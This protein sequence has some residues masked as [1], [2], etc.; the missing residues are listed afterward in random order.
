MELA[1]FRE[2]RVFCHDLD[3][4]RKELVSS[5]NAPALSSDEGNFV[6]ALIQNMEEQAD[7]LK[8]DVTEAETNLRPHVTLAD[9]IAKCSALYEENEAR[10][11]AMRSTLDR[12]Q[13]D[14]LNASSS[15]IQQTKK[16]AH[17]KQPSNESFIGHRLSGV[18]MTNK[19]NNE[20]V[21]ENISPIVLGNSRKGEPKTPSLEDFGISASTMSYLGA[22]EVQP[23]MQQQMAATYIAA[24]PYSSSAAFVRPVAAPVAHDVESITPV[25]KLS[26]DYDPKS[27]ECDRSI[28]VKFASETPASSNCASPVPSDVSSYHGIASASNMYK[29]TTS[30]V[31]ISQQQPYATPQ[32]LRNPLSVRS[33]GGSNLLPS[34]SKRSTPPKYRKTPMKSYLSSQIVDEEEEEPQQTYTASIGSLSSAG[35]SQPAQE[36]MSFRPV[37]EQ[38]LDTMPDYLKTGITA[39]ALNTIVE[40]IRQELSYKTHGESGC[41]LTLEELRAQVQLGERAKGTA[42]LLVRLQRLS[43]TKAASGEVVYGLT[44][45]TL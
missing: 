39:S 30:A 41:F 24:K 8:N 26:F 31:Y 33:D 12:S 5:V 20:A 16:Q 22:P 19:N 18:G 34:S 4:S 9:M 10:L 14:Q 42:L 21:K 1:F 43:M 44:K 3:R 2:L 35:R 11:A 29:A 13:L 38:E 37:T 27:S 23:H 15:Q 45:Q 25:K 17:S 36:S 28:Q 40:R 7:E 32:I 6:G